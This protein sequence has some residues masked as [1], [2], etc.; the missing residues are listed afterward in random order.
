MPFD[1]YMPL[2]VLSRSKMFFFLAFFVAL[3]GFVFRFVLFWFVGDFLQIR[4]AF[5]RALFYAP[6]VPFALLCVRWCIFS[7]LCFLFC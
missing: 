1:F 6:R 3:V 5:D 4:M 2:L 7:I